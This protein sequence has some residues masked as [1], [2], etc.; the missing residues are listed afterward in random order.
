MSLDDL[1]V[2]IMILTFTMFVGLVLWAWSRRRA[3]AFEEAAQLPF[4]R[5]ADAELT[6]VEN[7]R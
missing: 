6:P 3:T 4:Q 1:R 2:T 7:Q 5:A